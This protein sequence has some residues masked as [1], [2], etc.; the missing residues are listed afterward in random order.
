MHITTQPQDVRSGAVARAKVLGTS[1]GQFP[2]LL[3]ARALGK[4]SQDAS[5]QRVDQPDAQFYCIPEIRHS[6]EIQSTFFFTLSK[7]GKQRS[8]WILN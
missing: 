6:R 3:L 1:P 7:L 5:L 2:V 4:G 8:L